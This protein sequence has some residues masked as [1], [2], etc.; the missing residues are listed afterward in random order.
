MI[1]KI[2]KEHTVFSSRR[3]SMTG[4]A[5]LCLPP[6]HHWSMRPPRPACNP[7]AWGQQWQMARTGYT[8]QSTVGMERRHMMLG[9]TQI[10]LNTHQSPYKPQT[11]ILLN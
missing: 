2:R 3:Y 6:Y 1:V 8:E 5:V 4:P 10:H 11:V 9:C 7:P